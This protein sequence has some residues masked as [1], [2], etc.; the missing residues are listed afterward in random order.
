M[1][2]AS[3]QLIMQ[4]PALRDIA[5]T[6]E[7]HPTMDR[8]FIYRILGGRIDPNALYTAVVNSDGSVRLEMSGDRELVSSF[9]PTTKPAASAAP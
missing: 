5:V 3:R 2:R 7:V 6:F 4:A 1:A 8:H 9:P